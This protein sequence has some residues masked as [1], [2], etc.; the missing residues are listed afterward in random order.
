MRTILI[1]TLSLVLLLTGCIAPG[2]DEEAPPEIVAG[3]TGGTISAADSIRVR[4]NEPAVDGSKLN[5]PLE[6]SPINF[7]P[8]IDGE[9][10]WTAPDRLQFTPKHLLEPGR[11]YTATLDLREIFGKDR[12]PRNFEFEFSVMEQSLRVEIDGLEAADAS[13]PEL[14]R[15]AGLLTTAD[16]AD[17]QAVQKVL[18]ASHE[19]APLVVDWQAGPGRSYRFSIDGIVRQEDASAVA[20][21]W[22]GSAIGASA[23]GS[24][25]ITIPAR[26]DFD[27]SRIR[28]L[29]GREK[30]IEIRFTDPLDP[31]QDLR[32]LIRVGDHDDLRFVSD[33]SVLR[34]YT[35]GRWA[36]EEIAT[37]ERQVD[38]SLGVSLGRQVQRTVHFEPEKPKVAFSSEGVIVPSTDSGLTLPIEVT[39]LRAVRVEATQVF[40][41]NMAQF[42]QVN[43]L[44]DNDEMNRVGRVVWDRRVE[45]GPVEEASPDGGPLRYGL[46][47]GPLVKDFPGG[48]YHLKLSFT[49]ADIDW[50]CADD[51]DLLRND[52]AGLSDQDW[53][54]AE[55]TYWDQWEEMVGSDWSS[56]YDNRH[57]PCHRGFYR[58]YY[59]H[60]IAVERNVLLSNIGL[61]AK[62]GTDGSLTALVTDLRTAEPL[63]RAEVRVLDY[64][65]QPLATRI[66]DVNGL[67]SFE[68]E[69]E[70]FLIV[71]SFD[72]QIGYLKLDDGLALSMSTFDVSG[73]EVSN[74]IKGFLYAERGVWRPGDTMFIGFILS[75][76][77]DRLPPD[78]PIVFELRNSRDQLVEREVR[79]SSLNG[80][81]VFNVTTAPDAPTGDY[82][83]KLTVGGTTFEKTLK[84]AMVRP[85]RL[86]V[87]LDLTEPDIRAP[88]NRLQA[89][90]ESAWLHGAI[91][92]GLKATVE[93]RLEA[94]AT[95]F[96]AWPDFIFDDPTRFFDAEQEMIFD[97]R[98][99][100]KG[101]AE[102]DEKISAPANAPGKVTAVLTTRVFESGGAF[103]ILESRAPYSPYERY[104]GLRTPP[105]D[106]ARGMLL[107]DEDHRVDLVM[108]DQD[109][110]PIDGRATVKL[111]KISWRWWWEK[112]E[113][114]LAQFAG[115]SS[116]T[117]IAS[118]TVDLEAGTGNWAFQ[119]NY[120]EWGRYLLL[121][122]DEA[123]GHRTGKILYIDWPG[124]AGKARKGAADGA[125]VLAVASDKDTVSV[126]GEVTLTIPSSGSGRVLVSL[127][128]GTRVLRAEFVEA[129][130]ERTRYT[131]TATADMVPNIYASVISLQPHDHPQNDLPIRMYGVVPIRVEDPSSHLEPVVETPKSMKPETQASISVREADGRPMTYTVAVVDEGLLGLT[132]FK[133]PD[134]WSFF[135]R[136][137][138]LGVRTWDVYDEVV[139]AWGAALERLLAIGGDEAGKV[140]PGQQKTRRFPPMVRFLGPFEIAE[141]SRNTHEID[142]PLYV[143]A[144]RVM[145]VAGHG[146][147]FGSTEQEVPVRSPLMVLSTLPRVLAPEE[148]IA[149][150]ASV[151]TM[152]GGPREVKVTVTTEGPVTVE[153]PAE[154]ILRLDGP[155]EQ[156]LNFDLKTLDRDGPATIMVEARGGGESSHHETQITVRRAGKRVTDV[157]G[158]ELASGESWRLPVELPGIAGSNTATLE[159]SR[160]P[161]LDLERRLDFLVRYPY[162]CLEQTTSSVFPQ[163]YLA[164]L[165]KLPED[166]VTKIEAN[167]R[168]GI[169]RLERFQLSDGGF[170]SWPVVS[171]GF[172]G[173]APQ[174][175]SDEWGTSYAGHFLLQA[176]RAGYTVPAELLQHWEDFQSDRARSWITGGDRGEL[177]QAYR[178]HTLALAGAADLT[179]MNRLRE[180]ED[181]DAA[182]RWQL[183]AAYHRAGQPE[184][185]RQL[186]RGLGTS[187]PEYTELSGTYGT[188]LRDQ[189]MALETLYLLGENERA[190]ALAARVSE[191][192]T[193]DRWYS[194]QT[195]AYALLA[196]AQGAGIAETAQTFAFT[197][198]WADEQGSVEG[199][200]PIVHRALAVG[201]TPRGELVVE[202]SG[203]IAIY[204]RIVVSGMPSVA[205]VKGASN[206]LVIGVGYEDGEGEA[207]DPSRLDQ[208]LDFM[209]VATVHNPDDGR[210]LQGLA[211]SIPIAGG[212]E[213]GAVNADGPIEF[214]DV[215][216]DRVDVF[217]DLA[218]DASLTVEVRLNAAF[219][220]RYALA[221]T[222]V[223]AMYDATISARTAG[224][225]VKVVA[226]GGM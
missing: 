104:V 219:V 147:A 193:S 17:S 111:Y 103:S 221:T 172:W 9:A 52:D 27:V 157:Y 144:V 210:T 204:P 10:M 225:W 29:Q 61:V 121:A 181:L 12:R 128:S 82:R 72:Q 85:N 175:S 57:D 214:Q 96:D 68:L 209:M 179:A 115:A 4:L 132:G 203:E 153:G 116:L 19:G 163:L 74:G 95:R 36:N 113:D 108:A 218:P 89:Q 15:L 160:I 192:L 126:G 30:I 70:P 31:G 92:G 5:I 124:W 141:G 102:V 32:G 88:N 137:E 58:S 139:G 182:T 59:D 191:A 133:S 167:V 185:A 211:L 97:G 118:S 177:V 76:P 71:A 48:M 62:A 55:E 134:P 64:Q 106:K 22:D 205:S 73:A 77:D 37:V 127:E 67:A 46:D 23:T 98:L 84:V 190:A 142:V 165:L 212:W 187:F 143:G 222:T 206:N 148:T 123:G 112:G 86:K 201:E 131:F 99:N 2:M 13:K 41:S 11:F 194:T 43:N 109:G 40:D 184:T 107:T 87:A 186:V 75:D 188:A 215:R 49:R 28:A 159:V 164:Q 53:D 155:G 101:H 54:A 180:A 156:T 79:T 91:A 6:Q 8:P 129:R 152:Q 208:G 198:R 25:T 200:R 94:A 220:G 174:H 21:G 226:P 78:H 80:F 35:T 151:F 7:R 56:L 207:L 136:R 217:F 60:D 158:A 42:F 14:Q 51:F 1:P 24:T 18:E 169:Q 26:G 135:F 138:A 125:A 90:L 16:V 114:D 224:R 161:P 69:S 39:A 140:K 66:T 176:Q 50:Q 183:A 166:Q 223:E 110:K 130:E 213:I 47:L 146:R 195:T 33:G 83:A 63:E 196:I 45:F 149:L 100:S 162:G 44:E 122:E 120:P 216:D 171:G 20:L 81:S 117:P 145:V 34:I 197:Y 170:N 199:G 65:Q 178:L 168:S 150:P 38:N 189:A 119:V 202:N 154:R 93:A 105:G 173:Q 3:H